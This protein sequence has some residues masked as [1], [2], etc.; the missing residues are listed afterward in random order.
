ML[1][2]LFIQTAKQLMT[3]IA[4]RRQLDSTIA[5]FQSF[6]QTFKRGIQFVQEFTVYAQFDTVKPFAN[7]LIKSSSVVLQVFEADF[8]I[9]PISLT[10]LK[11]RHNK[12]I[13]AFVLFF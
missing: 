1:L 10:G 9:V 12:L 13:G 8:D 11:Q 3:L 7:T 5:E 4:M 6:L 2:P